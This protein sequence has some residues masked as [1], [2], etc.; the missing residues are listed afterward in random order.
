M[1]VYYFVFK[2]ELYAICLFL[3][4]TSITMKLLLA[5]IVLILIVEANAQWYKFPVEAAQGETY[6]LIHIAQGQCVCLYS[7]HPG[8]RVLVFY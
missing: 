8:L 7:I 3:F 5:G 1:Y 6:D 4:Q 2:G